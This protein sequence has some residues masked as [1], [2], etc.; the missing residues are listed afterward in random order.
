MNNISCDSFVRGTP[1]DRMYKSTCSGREFVY[2]LSTTTA[3]IRGRKRGR[4][5]RTLG[6][7]QSVFC[8]RDGRCVNKALQGSAV[9][10]IHQEHHASYVCI[11]A[12]RKE[13]G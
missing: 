7:K 8:R 4:V 11:H 9:Q 5:F 3:G 12:C 13:H 10:T 2:V 6:R 1:N